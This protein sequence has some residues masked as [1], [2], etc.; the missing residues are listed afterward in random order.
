[1]LVESTALCMVCRLGYRTD[2]LIKLLHSKSYFRHQKKK[3]AHQPLITMRKSPVQVTSAVHA[4][5]A[6]RRPHATTPGDDGLSK[7]RGSVVQYGVGRQPCRC[8]QINSLLEA[9]H[10]VSMQSTVPIFFYT[11]I[12]RRVAYIA[13][14]RSLS[15]VG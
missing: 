11:S 6:V 13:P 10:A 7:N 12:G 15:A 2:R 14:S 8:A 3:G 1:M 9:S 5:L 4:W